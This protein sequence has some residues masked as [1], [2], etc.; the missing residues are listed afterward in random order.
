MKLCHFVAGGLSIGKTVRVQQTSG[1]N[2]DRP[3]L[4]Q[5]CIRGAITAMLRRV[6][7]KRP[8]VAPFSQFLQS[9]HSGGD[10][11]FARRSLCAHYAPFRSESCGVREQTIS[12]F[13][14]A[15][16]PKT[17]C[18]ARSDAGLLPTLHSRELS[19]IRL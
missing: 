3:G 15:P 14:N 1:Q 5:A 12:V 6:R 18:N 17:I 4:S 7:R 8:S 13:R 19:G 2:G 16:H 10:L 9:T 11:R